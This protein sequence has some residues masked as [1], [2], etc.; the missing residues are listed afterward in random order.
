MARPLAGEVHRTQSVLKPRMLRRREDPPRA[1]QLMDPA[2]ALQPC[3]IH[4]VLLRCLACDT[5]RPPLCDAKVSVDGI[6][7]QVDARVLGTGLV[8]EPIIAMSRSC[9]GGRD[10]RFGG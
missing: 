2:Q 1:L 10:E 5:A 9:A 6:G 7:G 3:G 4:E 8:H